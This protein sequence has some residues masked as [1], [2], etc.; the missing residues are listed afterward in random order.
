MDRCLVGQNGQVVVVLVMAVLDQG[1]N[2]AVT[3]YHCVMVISVEAKMK[4]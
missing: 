2:H 3:Q 4:K 1:Q